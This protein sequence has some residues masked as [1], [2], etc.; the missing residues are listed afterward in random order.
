MMARL[1]QNLGIKLLSLACSFALFLYVHKQQT[2]E[3][4][5]QVP[6][7]ILLDPNT[8]VTDPAL[9]HRTVSVTLWGPAQRL[10][11]LERQT[12]A[13][14]DLRGHGSGTYSYQPVEVRAGSENSSEAHDPVDVNWTPRV[15][16]IELEQ[17]SARKLLVQPIFNVQPPPGFSLD[18][19][20]AVPNAAVVS[21]WESDLRRVKRLQAVINSFGS[22]S[23]PEIDLVVSVRAVDAQGLEVGEGIQVQPPT[24]KV[25]AT[26]ERSTWSKVVYVSP[27]LNDI[28]P[29]VRLQRM[30]LTPRR[31]TLRGPEDRVGPV[32]FLE[33]EPITIPNIPGVVDRDMRVILPP[34]VKT[35]ER[36]RVRVVM[37]LQGVK[38]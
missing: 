22:A 18:R 32:Q 37:A 28:P 1:G 12:R 7:V 24:I 17:R 36:P 35:V 2:S 31:L 10:K 29:T 34:G 20:R 26:L 14:A 16:S 23:L 4:Q 6:L 21:G 30:S 8:R 13:V 9:L 33:T 38:P 25:Q 15:I 3:V 11:D 5:F 19:A 27:V